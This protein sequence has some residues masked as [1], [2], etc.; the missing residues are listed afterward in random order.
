MPMFDFAFDWRKELETGIKKIDEQHQ[1]LFQIGRD[2]EQLIRV[3]CIG[4]T[5]KQLLDIVCE[6]RDFVAYHFYEEEALMENTGVE[7]LVKH[8]KEH[9][10]LKKTVQEFDV[11]ELKKNPVK[12]L[13][14]I[15]EEMQDAIFHHMLI[16]DIEMS[17]EVIKRYKFLKEYL[18]E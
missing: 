7:N 16:L 2:V 4:V 10:R 17:K 12:N 9:E 8:R 15:K 1:R 11:R 5:D 13:K 6:L 14:K 3:D 18:E